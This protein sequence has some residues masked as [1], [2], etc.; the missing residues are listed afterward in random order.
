MDKKINRSVKERFERA[1]RY[2]KWGILAMTLGGPISVI[3]YDV[4]YNSPI[5][6]LR[7]IKYALFFLFFAL[8]ILMVP[9]E[10][11]EDKN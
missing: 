5:E 8:V 10:Y 6:I 3:T 11:P 2:Q 7:L 9:D 4:L 1:I